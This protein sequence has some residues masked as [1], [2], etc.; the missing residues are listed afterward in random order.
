MKTRKPSLRRWISLVLLAAVP[1]IVA[2]AAAGGIG[3][4]AD[5][6]ESIPALV[7]NNDELVT[8]T[9]PDGTTQPVIA[10][11]L[12][13]TELTG[14]DN[15][16][17]SWKL[18][19]DEN[20]RKALERGDAYAV[21]TIP[22]N[23]SASIVSLGGSDPRQA[24]VTLTT[25]DA[26][27]YL[28][29]SVA[30]SLGTAM[31]ATL[32]Q[33]VTE[34]VLNGLFSNLSQFTT[35]MGDAAQG[36]RQLSTGVSALSDGLVQLS[37]GTSSAATGAAQAASGAREYA[38]GVSAYT[39]GVDSLAG[40]LSTLDANA[41]GL[42]PLSSGLTSYINGVSATLTARCPSDPNC[43][44]LIGTGTALA[45]GVSALPQ[46]QG[47]ITQSAAGAN[48]L[49]AGSAQLRSGANSLADGVG[50]I[51]S[52][53]AQL[54]DGVSQSASGAQQLAVGSSELATGLESGA[55]QAASAALDPETTAEII[56]N[57]IA[58]T[59]EV[60]DPIDSVRDLISLLVVPLALW[61]GALALIATRDAF[62]AS[63]LQSTASS[64]SVT[65]NA[66]VRSMPL[67]VAQVALVNVVAL[68]SGVS[69]SALLWAI[70]FTFVI[71]LAFGALHMLIKLVWPRAAVAVSIVAFAVQISVLPGVVPPQIL[72]PFMQ[73]LGAMMPLTWAANGMQAIVVGSN[74]GA[75]VSAAVGLAVVAA[76][77]VIA[78]VA[79]VA[80]RRVTAAWGFA[81]ASVA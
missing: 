81:V 21:V 25:S 10:G 52:G 39:Q 18:S 76:L 37:S 72:P 20:A 77:S 41:G 50:E 12:L 53:L 31:T 22:S 38:V 58:M 55:E 17:F 23:F 49:A 79:L 69:G 43:Q 67:L 34:Q 80:R 3:G 8:T 1:L 19:N 68:W 45:P 74:V 4:A 28:A 11:R 24:N 7:V 14:P 5:N 70:P 13:V 29:G 30:Q 62:D 48:Q 47:G 56:S 66:I 2:G 61:I 46:L 35:G 27:S 71:A 15:P 36:A 57:P 42:T 60:L 16:G 54:S 63:R 9:Q 44:T 59:S 65:L 51:A 78:S 6:I 32:G 75:A 33:Q 64:M 26:H 40:G 73:S